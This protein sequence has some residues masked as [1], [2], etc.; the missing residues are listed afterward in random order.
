[1]E[2]ETLTIILAE[3]DDGH[4]TL[5]RRNLERVRPNFALVR[6]NH[7]ERLL[8]YLRLEASRPGGRRRLLLLLDIRMPGMDGMEVLRRMKADA[9]LRTIPIY[10]LTTTDNPSEVAR[11]FELGCN[12]YLTKPVSSQDFTVTMERLCA[13][14]EISQIPMAP[15]EYQDATA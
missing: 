11:C 7:G 6:L 9:A 1:M 14:L 8:E 5:I 3:D 4:A 15:P 13:F 12:A 2:A 10:M